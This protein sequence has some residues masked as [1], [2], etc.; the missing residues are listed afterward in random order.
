MGRDKASLP[1]GAGDLLDHTIVR[2]S[3]VTGDVRILCGPQPRYEDRGRA[4]LPD[5]VADVGGLAALATALRALQPGQTALLLAVDLPSVPADLLRHLARAADDADAAVPASP[6]GAEPFC[7]A[8][9]SSC[10]PA[11]E[12]AIREGRLKM[13]GFWADVRILPVEGAVLAAFG[14]P[15]QMFSNLNTPQEYERARA[16]TGP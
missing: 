3:A 7:A 16:A 9:R 5:T 1:W 15:V 14:D 12:R 6:A 10:G 8:Y 4:V 11:V 13:T 2:L